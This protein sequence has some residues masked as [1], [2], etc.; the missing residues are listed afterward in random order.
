MKDCFIFHLGM[1]DER[2]VSWLMPCRINKHFTS[3]AITTVAQ[4]QA[5]L[6]H[7]MSNNDTNAAM[8]DQAILGP[9]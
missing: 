6:H 2:D 8:P 5:Q 7:L 9:Y 3:Q 1:K 4:M